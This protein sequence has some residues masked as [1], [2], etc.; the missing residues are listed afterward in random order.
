M[1]LYTQDRTRVNEIMVYDSQ[2]EDNER[3]ERLF[4]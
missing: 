1:V 4:G 2:Y 3:N